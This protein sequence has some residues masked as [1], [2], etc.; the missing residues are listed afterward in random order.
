MSTLSRL[1][2]LSKNNEGVDDILP[3]SNAL[4]VRNGLSALFERHGAIV[5]DKSAQP[6]RNLNGKPMDL[7]ELPGAVE[8]ENSFGK[9]III[10]RRFPCFHRHGNRIL[11]DI[12]HIDMNLLALLANAPAISSLQYNNALFLDTETTGLA[13]GTGTFIFLT[14]L[15]WFEEDDF[16]IQQIF[17]RD[18]SEERSALATLQ[19]IVT[20]KELLVSFNGKAFDVSLLTAR[21]ILNRLECP[22][23][24][25]PHLD[26]LP[27]ARS[28]LKH[29]LDDR[30]LGNIEQVVLGIRRTGD[31]S[32]MEIPQRYFDWLRQRDARLMEDVLNHNSLD[33][34]SLAVLASH[35]SE[36]LG[37]HHNACIPE[38]R[39]AAGYFCL[40]RGEEQ[41]AENLLKPLVENS[42]AD[43]S[44]KARLHL[45]LIY[46]RQ[47]R[48]AEAVNIWERMVSDEPGDV[49]ARVEL[50]KWLEHRIGDMQKAKIHIESSLSRDLSICETEK[51]SLLLRLRRLDKRL[52]RNK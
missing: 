8:V 35:F 23:N 47:N 27:P 51:N 25:M 42:H 11:G 26:L 19:K 18:F 29:R 10:S 40:L 37:E 24:E 2:R 3:S 14:G 45:S 22:L 34:L 33:V 46:K 7:C 6:P 44:R 13:G 20:G 5:K 16:I 48:W 28:L 15:G 21:F 52:S 31:I 49:F 39:L 30:R 32:G 38:D 36:L 4:K 1:K 12:R 43:I 9:H 17:A 50:A 41:R